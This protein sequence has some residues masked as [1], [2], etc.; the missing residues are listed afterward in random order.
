MAWLFVLQEVSVSGGIVEL[1]GC[2]RQTDKQ[3]IKK[4][5][6]SNKVLKLIKIT[7]PPNLIVCELG[8]KVSHTGS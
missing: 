3:S 4:Q 2:K 8:K 1:G 6:W 7:A 5:G